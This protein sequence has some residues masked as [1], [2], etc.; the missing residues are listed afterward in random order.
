MIAFLL[1]PML[2]TIVAWTC[3]GVAFARAG[4]IA[5]IVC[6]GAV[7]VFAGYALLKGFL[8][9]ASTAAL[10][11]AAVVWVP[12]GIAIFATVAYFGKRH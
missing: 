7:F 4:A 11:V 9:T 10:M 2:S 3:P 12:Q 5:G 8:L 1:C 6:L